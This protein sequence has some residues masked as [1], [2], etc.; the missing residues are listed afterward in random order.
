MP[1][2][3]PPAPGKEPDCAA[4]KDQTEA[5]AGGLQRISSCKGELRR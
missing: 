5:K 1:S 3:A 4:H 2:V